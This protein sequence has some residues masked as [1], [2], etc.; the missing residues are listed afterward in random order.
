MDFLSLQFIVMDDIHI[1]FDILSQSDACLNF[2]ISMGGC[3]SNF[4][5]LKKGR[6]GRLILNLNIFQIDI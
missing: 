3:S 4:H 2:H 5:I 1:Q 6:F